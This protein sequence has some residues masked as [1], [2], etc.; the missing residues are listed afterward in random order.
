VHKLYE[1]INR[2]E[3]KQFYTKHLPNRI[4]HVRHYSIKF[5][6]RSK[7]G[8]KG[9]KGRDLKNLKYSIRD[10]KVCLGD[11]CLDFPNRQRIGRI[12]KLELRKPTDGSSPINEYQMGPNDRI[13]YLSARVYPQHLRTGKRPS[14]QMR[15]RTKVMGST[16]DDT[17]H[18]IAKSL[19]GPGDEAFNFF[20]QKMG[21]NR[22]IWRLEEKNIA[23]ALR[24]GKVNYVEM[25]FNFKYKNQLD[26]R[27]DYFMVDFEYDTAGRS[28]GYSR[29][30]LNK[31]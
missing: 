20:P 15:E 25:K 13:E 7:S 30:I 14:L 27:P 17:G 1:G 31:K 8:L 10:G 2:F 9:S 5:N 19:G 6:P 26:T 4:K 29:S 28:S 16:G 24:S 22:G 11:Y 3:Y 21:I 12:D 23:N 18:L